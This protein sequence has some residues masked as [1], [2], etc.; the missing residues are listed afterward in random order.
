MI[1]CLHPS[2]GRPEQAF[3]TYQN[4]MQKAVDKN[5]QWVLSVDEDDPKLLQYKN[6][7]VP[8]LGFKLHL[9]G[10]EYFKNIE[11]IVNPNKNLI[12]AVNA[13]IKYIKGDLVVVV[14]DDFDCPDEWDRQL[15]D[16]AIWHHYPREH[17]NEPY[18]IYI[19]DGISFGRKCMTL[20]ILS[21]S[22]IDKSGYIYYPGYDGMFADNDLYE[23][24]EKLGVIITKDI[25][26]QHK[27]WVN[28]MAE[29][30]ATYNR[31]NTDKSWNHGKKL[32]A[33]RRAEN[34][35]L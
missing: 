28:G 18:A 13:G 2:R 30:D 21:K 7:L 20:P 8:E 24:C 1:T 14:S 33:K 32:L 23:V 34:F 3:S 35:N 12:Q 22:L 10:T 16:A 19:N 29:R 4:W 25:L 26:F 15:L 6:L 9:S 17:R 31:H 5:I 27:H 11:I